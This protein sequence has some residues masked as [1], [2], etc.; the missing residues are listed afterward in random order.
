MSRTKNNPTACFI[1]SNIWLYAFIETPNKGD[2]RKRRIAK[3][4]IHENDVILWVGSLI[5]SMHF[6]GMIVS[7]NSSAIIILVLLV[8]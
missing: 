7:L 2:K 1:D 6:T 5:S 8:N 3:Q 4:T